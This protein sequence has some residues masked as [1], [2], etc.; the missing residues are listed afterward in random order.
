MAISA[1][2]PSDSQTLA[3]DRA[4]NF[5]LVSD[6]NLKIIKAYGVAMRGDDIAVPSMFIVVPG[7]EI[8][9][10]HIS[11]NMIDRP[12][13]LDVVRQVEAWSEKNR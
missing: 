13:P 3:A 8:L 2:L 5:A 1:D 7:G 12:R 10:Q 11:G 9:Y 6:P 4:L